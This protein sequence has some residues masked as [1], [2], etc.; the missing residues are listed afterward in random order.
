[1]TQ[2]PETITS[3]VVALALDAASLRQQV[4]AANIANASTEGY[5][6]RRVHFESQLEQAR[7]SLR[8]GRTVDPLALAG[9]RAAIVPATDAHGQGAPV[10]LDAEMASLAQNAVHYQALLKGLA[11]HHAMLS[12][13]AGDGRK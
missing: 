11:Q 6:A 7:R 13:A 8:A 9:V 3:A 5:A 10:R 4:I 12:L 2:G 1:M